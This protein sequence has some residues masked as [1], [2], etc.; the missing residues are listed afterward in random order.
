MKRILLALLLALAPV[1]A[2]AQSA[3]DFPTPNLG[4]RV[5]LMVMGCLNSSGYAVPATA[6]GTCLGS[7][8]SSG[9]GSANAAT[10]SNA[11]D[12][13]AT[14]ATNQNNV[15]YNYLFNGTTWDRVRG[16]GGSMSMFLS[17]GAACRD[18]RN[19]LG[20]RQQPA[21]NTHASVQCRDGSAVHE[22][23]RCRRRECCGGEGR[24]VGRMTAADVGCQS[25]TN[26]L[27]ASTAAA[28]TVSCQSA[29]WH[30][31]DHCR[32]AFKASPLDDPVVASHRPMPLFTVSAIRQP[33]SRRLLTTTGLSDTTGFASIPGFQI[34]VQLHRFGSVPGEQQ[35]GTNL[36]RSRRNRRL[37]R[38]TLARR[39]RL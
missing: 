2:W 32:R 22:H 19:R 13:Q 4:E 20:E 9:G 1:S 23:S 29:P 34:T 15:V 38:A 21:R 17:A 25:A 26:P 12:G 8:G 7:G 39:C 11:T 10:T 33:P 36:V 24:W 6:A 28:Q 3:R 5:P 18:E 16:T 14:T 37:R 35:I 27:G 31:R 30:D